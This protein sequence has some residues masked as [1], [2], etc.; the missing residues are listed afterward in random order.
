MIVVVDTNIFVSA[1]ITP[2]S[3]L[4]RILSYHSLSIKRIS[5]HILIA[6]LSKHHDK[7]VKAS[8]RTAKVV[9][10]DMYAYLQY[11]KLYEENVIMPVHWLEADRLTKGVDIDDI[12]LLPWRCKP[13]VC[14]GRAIRNLQSTLKQWDLAAY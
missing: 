11:I 14:Y 2:N 10:D 13:M 4:A 5:S 7:I 12:A 6:E 8:K 3:R 1:L 9:S